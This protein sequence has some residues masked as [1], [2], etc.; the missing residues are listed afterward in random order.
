MGDRANVVIKENNSQVWLYTHWGGHGLFQD[1]QKAL[2]R[3]MERWGDPA[4][5]A[6]I[7]F[8]EMVPAKDRLGLT[9]FGISDSIGD[10]EHPIIVLDIPTQSA[11]H[12]R[13]E[14]LDQH[15]RLPNDYKPLVTWP[16]PQ[17]VALD[18]DPRAV[19]ERVT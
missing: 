6:R 18:E 11:F 5:L 17:F 1:V 7:V 9:G 3:G 12:V 4:S 14:D 16:F 8:S 13:E 19:V 10:N 15:G 2:A